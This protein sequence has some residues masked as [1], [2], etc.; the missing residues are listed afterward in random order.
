M[1]AGAAF[2]LDAGQFSAGEAASILKMI[3]FIAAG[4]SRVPPLAVAVVL[5]WMW[6]SHDAP[7]PTLT[8]APAM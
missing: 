7:P 2:D 3:L 4:I 5:L 1:I 8:S 6:R